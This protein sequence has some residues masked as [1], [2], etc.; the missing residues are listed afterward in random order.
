MT[1]VDV[2]ITNIEWEND[3]GYSVA[4]LHGSGRVFRMEFSDEDLESSESIDEA[5]RNYIE[6]ETGFRPKSWYLYEFSN[7]NKGESQ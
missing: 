1:T 2:E 4:Y 3:P 6:I 5:I 7:V